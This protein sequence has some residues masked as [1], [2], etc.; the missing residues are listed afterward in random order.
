MLAGETAKKARQQTQHDVRPI[1]HCLTEDS[2][3]LYLCL[4]PIQ[5]KPASCHGV[6]VN[7]TGG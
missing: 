4:L 6:S 1:L 7:P 5:A 2:V 3:S